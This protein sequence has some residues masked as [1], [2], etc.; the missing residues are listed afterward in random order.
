[1][2]FLSNDIVLE[3]IRALIVFIIVIYLWQ[4]SGSSFGNRRTGWNLIVTGFV[5]LLFGCLMDITD[6]IAGLEVFVVIGDTPTQAFLEKVVGFLGGFSIL[7]IGLLRWIPLV[8]NLAE[9]VEKQTKDLNVAIGQAKNAATLKSQFLSNMSHE[10]RTPMNGI[11][12]STGLILASDISKEARLYANTALTSAESLLSLINDILD[13]SKIEAKKLELETMDFDFQ[14]LLQDVLD[15]YKE[16]ARE[17][18]LELIFKYD[19]LMPKNIVGDPGRI[20]Q[21]IANLLSNAIKFTKSGHIFIKVCNPYT[22]QGAVFLRVDVEDTGI[23]VHTDKQAGI[24]S[25]FAETSTAFSNKYKGTGLGLSISQS[26]ARLMDGVI[27]LSSETN[28]GSVFSLSLPLVESDNISFQ[29]SYFNRKLITASKAL[30]IDRNQLAAEITAGQLTALGGNAITVQ[31]EKSAI[32]E[33]L[34]AATSSAPF[35]II[36]VSHSTGSLCE[37]TLS[38]RIRA[39]KSIAGTAMILAL[40]DP[41]SESVAKMKKAGFSGYINKP[42]FPGVVPSIISGVLQSI[43]DGVL[44]PFITPDGATGGESTSTQWLS[45]FKARVLLVEDNPVNLMLATV[46]LQKFGCTVAPAGDGFEALEMFNKQS[47]DLIFMDCQ[48]PLMG[49]LEAAMKIR[50]IEERRHINRTPIIAFT[51]NAM[52]GDQRDCITAGM[53]DYLAKP[54]SRKAFEDTLSR[55]IK[56]MAKSP[57]ILSARNVSSIHSGKP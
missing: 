7:A 31:D 22:K 35:D 45:N 21:I 9:E 37:E 47:F 12:G 26:L 5:L 15:I 23:G 46:I 27:T 18:D 32:D 36:I 3:S 50:A 39:Q 11:I 40:T 28:V 52:E 1:M 29:K 30:I 2:E 44:S 34:N 49:G 8:Q 14:T 57:S 51:A 42:V 19:T 17:K 54:V 13:F 4:I 20:R 38:K 25:T 6:E 48:M 41:I 33:L 55:W 43:N 16:Q 10:I 53:D 24:F 56:P